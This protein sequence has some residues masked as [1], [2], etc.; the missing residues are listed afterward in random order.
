[1]CN[2]CECENSDKCS[3]VGNIPLGFC[4]PKCIYYTGD[5]ACLNSK[6]RTQEKIKSIINKIDALRDAFGKKSKSSEEEEE[7][8]E[9]EKYP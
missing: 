1:M 7:T 3:I 9:L 8:Q 4:C 6:M 2:Y 5:H